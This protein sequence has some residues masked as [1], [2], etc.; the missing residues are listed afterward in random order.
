[1]TQKSVLIVDDDENFTV[2]LHQALTKS[3]YAAQAANDLAGARALLDKHVPDVLLLD[4]MLPDGS[5][6][7]LLEAIKTNPPRRVALITGHSSVKHFVSSVAGPGL[8]YL[9]KPVGLQDIQ[10]LLTD[11]DAE[12][13]EG[14]PGRHFGTLIGDSEPMQSVY[15]QIR[16]VAPGDS[17]VF[18]QGESGTGKELVAQAIHSESGRKGN[19]VAVN[20]GGLTRELV[21]SELFGHEK[22]SFTGASR[23]HAG[24]FERAARGTLFLDEITEMPIEMQTQLLRVL[25]TG[26]FNRVGGEQELACETRLVAASN[27]DP[28]AAVSEGKLREDL[29]FR[30]QVFPIRLPPLRDRLDDLNLLVDYFLR[31][32]NQKQQSNKVLSADYI[33]QLRKHS[34]PGNVREL[35]H[36]VQRTYILS[37]DD[38]IRPPDSFDS[39][40]DDSGRFTVGRSIR[41]ME[42]ELIISTLEHFNGDKKAA[43]DVLGVSLKTLYNRLNDYDGSG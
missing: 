20:C 33:E 41:D 28:G 12:T 2:A 32:F 37:S 35:K 3:G 25:E 10:K 1:M 36:M 16:Q 26:R 13:S 30:L 31:E 23:Q 43:A 40:P 34:W 18:V 17:T 29:Y 11:M 39:S 19:F 6:L 5:G 4:I 22:G 21:A 14:T 42:Q 27:V 38:T 9:I 15:E 7:D 24:Y 8:S